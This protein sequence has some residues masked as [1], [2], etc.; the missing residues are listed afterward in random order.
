MGGKKG[1]TLSSRSRQE[2]AILPVP[3]TSSM[4]HCEPVCGIE[5]AG[6]ALYENAPHAK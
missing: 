4:L 1:S 6:A 3:L 2:I 5:T